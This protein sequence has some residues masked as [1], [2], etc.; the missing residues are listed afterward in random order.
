[1]NDEDVVNI[2]KSN[3]HF[4]LC[5]MMSAAGAGGENKDSAELMKQLE[6]D[7]SNLLKGS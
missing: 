1:M 6:I 2:L 4:L 3:G 5:R 7:M